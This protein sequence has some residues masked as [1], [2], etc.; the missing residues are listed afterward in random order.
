MHNMRKFN[1]RKN[2]FLILAITIFAVISSLSCAFA[3]Y[4]VENDINHKEDVNPIEVNVVDNVQKLIKYNNC[5][6]LITKNDVILTD[7]FS[8][9][10]TFDNYL[11]QIAKNGSLENKDLEQMYL[12]MG[13]QAV[14]TFENSNLYSYV[15]DKV[16]KSFIDF[17]YPGSNS[18]ILKIENNNIEYTSNSRP[19]FEYGASSLTFNI[20]INQS[21]ANSYFYLYNLVEINSLTELNGTFNFDMNFHFNIIDE[22]YGYCLDNN[23]STFSSF[24]KVK[25]DISCLSFIG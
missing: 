1:I 20:S 2:K 5:N 16:G 23:Y 24:G 25:I 7:D 3:V 21:Y 11:Y 18:N 4:I 15:K 8:A 22:Y 6:Y 13:I 14:V 10:F 12:N 19:C 9:N 17:S